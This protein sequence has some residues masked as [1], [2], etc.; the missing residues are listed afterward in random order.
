L[1]EEFIVPRGKRSSSAQL[2]A[3]Q[4]QYVL[5]RLVKDRRVS[6]ADVHRYIGDMHREITQLEQRL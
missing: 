3:G 4:A 2:S 1:K 5:E 6:A